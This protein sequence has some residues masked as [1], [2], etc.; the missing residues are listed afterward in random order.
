VLPHGSFPVSTTGM[1]SHAMNLS[2]EYEKRAL[3]FASI[4]M[5]D[6]AQVFAT[7]ALSAATREANDAS[8]PTGTGL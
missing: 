5:Y 6:A 2:F 1:Q 8:I 7:L 4:G 3:H